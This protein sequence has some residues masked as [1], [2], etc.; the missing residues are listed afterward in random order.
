VKTT[1]PVTGP[2]TGWMCG[3]QLRPA[4]QGKL[5]SEFAKAGL[6]SKIQ[7]RHYGAV[8]DPELLDPPPLTEMASD[9]WQRQQPVIKPPG[10]A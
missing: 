6:A 2:P 3:F 9:G 10:S 8:H 1:E 5:Q 7:G 4:D